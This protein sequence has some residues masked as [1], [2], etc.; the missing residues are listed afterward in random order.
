MHRDLIRAGQGPPPRNRNRRAKDRP[1]TAPLW[2][3]SY[4][5]DRMRDRAPIAAVLTDGS[6]LRGEVEWYD[7]DCVNVLREDGVTVLVFRHAIRR[8]LDA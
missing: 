3:S 7:R 4:Y 6:V 2:E 1:E 8:F 5:L